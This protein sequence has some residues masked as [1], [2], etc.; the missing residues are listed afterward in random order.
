V[1]ESGED[2]SPRDSL[3]STPSVSPPPRSRVC[4]TRGRPRAAPRAAFEISY[5]ASLKHLQPRAM[6]ETRAQ[7]SALPR[8]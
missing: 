6:R 7:G 8:T 3:T 5:A 1:I 4:Q 2:L